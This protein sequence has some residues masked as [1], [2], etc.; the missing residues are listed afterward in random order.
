M[1]IKKVDICFKVVCNHRCF[2]NFIFKRESKF[3][4]FICYFYFYFESF[5]C[6]LLL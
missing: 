4:F 5:I 6:Y 2:Y 1:K 3:M